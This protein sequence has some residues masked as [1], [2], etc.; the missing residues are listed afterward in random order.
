LSINDDYETTEDVLLFETTYASLIA[1]ITAGFFDQ[2]LFYSVE[3]IIQGVPKV[4]S[5]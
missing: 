1:C 3:T 2:L 5:S 4:V